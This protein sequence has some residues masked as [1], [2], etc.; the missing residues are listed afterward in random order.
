MPGQ[1]EM[2]IGFI[3]TGF[4]ADYY[5]TTLKNHPELQ[6]C[7][8]FDRSAARMQ[9][10]AAFH[11]VPAYDSAEA[12]LGDPEIRIAVNLTTPESHFEVSRQALE[13]GKH[14]Y[15]EKPLAMNVEDATQLVAMAEARGLT[16][17]TAPANALSDAH[18]LVSSAL[19]AGRIGTPRLVY[20]EMEDG[21]VFRSNWASWRSQ[22][23]APWPGLHEFEIGCTLEHAGY[24]LSWL[25]SLFGA[26]ES[27]TAF[28]ALTFPDKGP[29]T[30]GIVMA[31]DFSVGCLRFRSGTV[32]RLTSGLAAPKDR[33]LTII[34]DKGSIVVRDLWDNRSAVFLEE[35]DRPRKLSTIL[36]N[37]LETR[38]K[39]FLPWKP[40]PGRRL[41]YPTA[42]RSAHLPGF[43]SQIDFC[44]GIAA[45]ARAIDSRRAPVLLGQPRPAHHRAGL[46]AEQCGR[47][48]SRM[49]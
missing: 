27:L 48:G 39:R 33:S 45:Q 5:M 28:S 11:G 14:V 4:V 16:L 1:L 41:R 19:D 47:P 17:A 40:N 34:G 12:L 9:E 26:V 7:G 21:P 2:K 23:G 43:P 32:A 37:R 3:G 22:S 35:L 10:F 49:W 13:A 25:V 20:A 15:C 24:A 42:A 8:V 44:A 36:A 31:P 6:L 29:G 38:L 30:Q 18:R 46:G